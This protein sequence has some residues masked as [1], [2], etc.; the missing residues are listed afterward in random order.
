MKSTLLLFAVL[1]MFA[2]VAFA[3]EGAAIEGDAKKEA[4]P[5]EE[6]PKARGAEVEAD[7]EVKEVK[8]V[9]GDK[10]E[11]KEVEG[12]KKEGADEKKEAAEEDA[13]IKKK[14]AAA[15]EEEP[16]VKKVSK[17]K[18]LAQDEGEGNVALDTGA[19]PAK[20]LNKRRPRSLMQACKKESKKL[21]KEG[22]AI[23]KC[24]QENLEQIDDEVCKSWVA[25]R[26][27]CLKDAEAS[28]KCEKKESPRACLRKLAVKDVSDECG[29]S[30]FFK[31]VQ[32][33][34][35]WRRRHEPTGGKKE[36]KADTQ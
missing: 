32:M 24:L 1:V 30:D 26:Q 14:A 18:V 36:R 22:S 23:A 19:V 27:A 35:R 16:V 11:V 6:K 5:E 9:E 21:C 3:E 12:D 10:K 34:T 7:K 2:V 13:P 4:A 28:P 31:A 17:K 29:D 8:E 33:Y 15:D 25:S 20:A